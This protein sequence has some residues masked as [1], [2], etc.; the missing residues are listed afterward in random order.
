L[1]HGRLFIDIL[2]SNSFS[3]TSQV[4]TKQY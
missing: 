3:T 4:I 2:F 1:H